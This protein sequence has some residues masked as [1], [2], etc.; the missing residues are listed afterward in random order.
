VDAGCRLKPACAELDI[1][2]RTFQRWVQ[3]G[4]DAVS[5]D[6]RTTSARPEPA[7][8]LSD[9]ERG[10]ILAVA[11]SEEFASLP[12]SQIVPALA[13]RGVFIA[14]ESSF[15]RVLKAA[16]QQHHRGRAKK[17]S[18]RVLTS[19]CATG[20]NQVW[21]WD[22]TWLPAAIKGQYYYW[23]M[24][25]DVFSRKIVGHEVHVAES[26]ELAS[27]LMRRASLAEGLAGRPLV[28]HSDN[29]SAMKGATMLATL[30]QLGV[31]PSF[32]RP[33]VSNDNAYAE[34]LF[35]TCKYR[36]DYPNKPFGSLEEAQAWTQQFVRWYNQ[37]HRH[38]GLKFVTPAQRHE[39]RDAAILA[40]REQVYR[41]A[42]KR[43]PQRWSQGTRNWKLDDQVWLNPE[44]IRPEDLKQAA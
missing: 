29:G 31:A 8:K 33:R 11:N 35:R 4:D 21:S 30:E 27:L 26:A 6:S 14:S 16:L 22:I 36:P 28:L 34:S 13:D 12:P 10:Q 5:A 7:N 17:P 44:R 1:S 37:V 41:E 9:D 19:H 39:G 43:N 15:Y 18:S 3:D 32:S 42:K 20:P 23:Y 40:H 38:S 24:V 2:L 25:L